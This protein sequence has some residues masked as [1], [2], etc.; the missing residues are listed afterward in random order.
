MRCNNR[1]SRRNGNG[2]SKGF[3]QGR[4]RGNYGRCTDKR[5][6]PCRKMHRGVG[7]L[8]EELETMDNRRP[9]CR[10]FN[11]ELLDEDQYLALREELKEEIKKELKEM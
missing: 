4:S 2:F 9:Y 11:E 10:R 7:F 1:M 5:D 3:G 6:F 8:E